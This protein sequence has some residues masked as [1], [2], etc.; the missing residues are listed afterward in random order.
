MSQHGLAAHAVASSGPPRWDV[1]P[2][3][4]GFDGSCDW[5]LGVSVSFNPGF[6]AAC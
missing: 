3:R 1:T 2:A 5:I 4:M 6:S